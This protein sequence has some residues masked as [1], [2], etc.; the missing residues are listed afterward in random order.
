M[1]RLRGM[2]LRTGTRFV[3]QSRPP[4]VAAGR[5]GTIVIGV[6]RRMMG[7]SKRLDFG[8]RG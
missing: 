3:F 4:P 7:E 1:R 6:N 8:L 2:T 5:Q